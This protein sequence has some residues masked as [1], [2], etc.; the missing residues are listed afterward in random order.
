MTKVIK[1]TPERINLLLSLK[2][3]GKKMKDIA[4]EMGDSESACFKA[5]YKTTHIQKTEPEDIFSYEDVES[6]L[7]ISVEEIQNLISESKLRGN[8]TVERKDLINFVLRYPGSCEK[9][10]VV[11]IIYLLG[12][13]K[14]GS[15]LY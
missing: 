9:G 2:T 10:D 14:C 15:N 4:S 6:I 11:Q 7:R 3:Q 13:E 5:I 8:G 1:W 12:G